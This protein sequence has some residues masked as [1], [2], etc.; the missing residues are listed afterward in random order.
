MSI[1]QIELLTVK[2]AS[3]FAKVNI[4]TIYRWIDKRKL[5]VFRSET[6]I[7]R[8]PKENL[9]SFLNCKVNNKQMAE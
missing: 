6:G 9:L 4:Y 8:I 5:K 1:N 3:E 7:I 2:E